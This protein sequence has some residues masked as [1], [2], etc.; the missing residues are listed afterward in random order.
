MSVPSREEL[1][2]ISFSGQE[3]SV[4]AREERAIAAPHT[5]LSLAPAT[6]ASYPT[7]RS[8]SES[9]KQAVIDAPIAAALE[10]K[11]V[12]TAQE[13]EDRLKTRRSSSLSSD[14]SKMRFLRLGPVHHGEGDALGDWSEEVA[15]EE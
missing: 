7:R 4:P 12:P 8:C 9:P 14:G 5:F 13:M 11:K 15:I 10:E 3:N 2:A 6:S 1:L